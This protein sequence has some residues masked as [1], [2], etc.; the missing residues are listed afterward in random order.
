MAAS[1]RREAAIFL[2]RSFYLTEHRICFL[3]RVAEINAATKT[4][5]N[6]FPVQ[7]KC[8][9]FS[10]RLLQLAPYNPTMRQHH[11]S[12]RPSILP[13]LYALPTSSFYLCREVALH[14]P[15]IKNHTHRLS[16]RVE[17]WNGTEQC[18]HI[19]IKH[20]FYFS[21]C[22][23]LLLYILYTIHCSIV[24]LFQTIDNTGF[25]VEQWWNNGT[26]LSTFVTTLVNIVTTL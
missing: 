10:V 13:E 25:F 14:I 24:P 19:Y 16:C 5:Q 11:N 23:N 12:V 18:F 15:L 9:W 8:C 21:F 1:L 6:F 17:Q 4:L 22:T 20:N 2:F 26:M 3:L 7:L